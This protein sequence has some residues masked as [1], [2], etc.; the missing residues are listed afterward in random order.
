MISL[1]N[2]IYELNAFHKNQDCGYDMLQK[3]NH[4]LKEI[5]FP[6]KNDSKL[7]L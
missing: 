4:S 2:E 6:L 3:Q 1:G 7:Q 5:M